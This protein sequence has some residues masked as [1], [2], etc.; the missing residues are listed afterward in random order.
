MSDRSDFVRIDNLICRPFFE[1]RASL[2]GELNA[3]P[4][5]LGFAVGF[6]VNGDLVLA[7]TED[8]L[9]R[10]DAVSFLHVEVEATGGSVAGNFVAFGTPCGATLRAV[11]GVHV[12]GGD[13]LGGCDA[14]GE[15]VKKLHVDQVVGCEMKRIEKIRSKKESDVFLLTNITCRA[16]TCVL[17][18]FLSQ[19]YNLATTTYRRGLLHL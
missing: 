15:Q 2:R 7:V 13:S 9:D 8:S 12:P 16:P 3:R 1:N 17:Y 4:Q 10:V 14:A 6:G 5:G 19:S 11:P 18:M